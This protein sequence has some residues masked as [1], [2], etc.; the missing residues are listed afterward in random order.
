M[1]HDPEDP[2]VPQVCR[3]LG[4]R[5]GNKLRVAYVGW[6]EL[7]DITIPSEP[8]PKEGIGK[9]IDNG[10]YILAGAD[11]KRRLQSMYDKLMKV[12]SSKIAAAQ[13]QRVGSVIFTSL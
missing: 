13:R 1:V 10:V 5:P 6:S 11:I 7:S 2:E 12:A 4:R 3:V 9:S 8:K